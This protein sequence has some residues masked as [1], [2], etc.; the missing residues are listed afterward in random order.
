M[1]WGVRGQ[2]KLGVWVGAI[3]GVT[4][5]YDGDTRCSETRSM[6]CFKPGSQPA[7]E[8][9]V[10]PSRVQWS[11]G[12]VGLVPEVLG[13]EVRSRERADAMCAAKFGDGWRMA[14][15]HDAGDWGYG[16]VGELPRDAMFWVAIRDQ[17]ANLWDP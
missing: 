15:F 8:G 10:L 12:E 9:L 3:D 13:L 5:A 4:N 14:E 7:P 11:G 16:A 17:R 1:T 2:H 6:L